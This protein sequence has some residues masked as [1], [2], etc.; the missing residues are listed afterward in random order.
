MITIIIM[1]FKSFRFSFCSLQF[2]EKMCY[3]FFQ[4][5]EKKKIFFFIII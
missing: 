2:Q 5:N 1:P 3:L 4:C